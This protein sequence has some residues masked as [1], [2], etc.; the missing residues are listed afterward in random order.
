MYDGVWGS[1]FSPRP[2]LLLEKPDSSLRA[3]VRVVSL[4]PGVSIWAAGSWSQDTHDQDYAASLGSPWTLRT[5]SG[6]RHP[7]RRAQRAERIARRD[8][9]TTGLTVR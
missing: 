2:R 8:T 4:V 5:W 3:V 7:I 9:A 6:R 1:I